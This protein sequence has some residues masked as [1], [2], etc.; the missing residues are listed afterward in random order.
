MSLGRGVAA[1][2]GDATHEVAVDVPAFEG[3][4][5]V[6]LVLALGGAEVD[7]E[8]VAPVFGGWV[9]AVLGER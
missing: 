8:G 6:G 4:G 9:D 2:G 1:G 7:D 5:Q 3:L